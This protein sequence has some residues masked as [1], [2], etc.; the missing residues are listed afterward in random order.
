MITKQTMGNEKV[1]PT[2]G[3]MYINPSEPNC[4]AHGIAIKLVPKVVA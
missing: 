1:C 3:R 4:I 2:C